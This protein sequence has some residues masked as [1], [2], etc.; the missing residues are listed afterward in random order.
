MKIKSLELTNWG[1][2]KK[3]SLQL[4]AGVVGIIGAN[5]KGKSNL[6][7][8][9]DY[10]LT[11]NL[12]KQKQ[13]LYIH[14]FGSPDG[15]TSASVKLIFEKGGKTGEITRTI[16]ASGS[17]RKLIWDESEWTKAAD[18]DQVMEAILG[19]DKAS[20][21]QA[22]FVKQGD[23]ARLVKGT[24]AER[25]TIFQ[26]LM[27]LG[28]LESCPDDIN[29]KIGAI[30]G[31]LQDMRPALELAEQ[32]MEDI[33]SKMQELEPATKQEQILAKVAQGINAVAVLMQDI[34][35]K[36]L[37]YREF[38]GH[39]AAAKESLQMQTA[40]L[41]V[42]GPDVETVR[43]AIEEYT[44]KIADSAANITAYNAWVSS[45]T[46]YKEA[47]AS[48]DVLQE[49][50]AAVG[51][52][53]ELRTELQTL[54]AEYK[55]STEQL[56]TL[57]SWKL[58][59][60]QLEAAK[61]AAAAEQKLFDEAKAK[62]DAETPSII[63]AL[64]EAEQQ[65][66]EAIIK[67]SQAEARFAGFL[68]SDAT[69]LCPICG[70][71]L[72]EETFMQPGE[73]RE[74]CCKRLSDA[75]ASIKL[76]FQERMQKIVLLDDKLRR[77][78]TGKH[79][80]VLKSKKDAVRALQQQL[81]SLDPDGKISYA[82]CEFN[83]TFVAALNT[84]MA[85]AETKI[86]AL[87][88]LQA[89]VNKAKARLVALESAM[90]VTSKYE[91]VELSELT[92]SHMQLLEHKNAM[93]S[94]VHKYETA[95]AAHTQA[96]DKETAL[97]HDVEQSNDALVQRWAELEQ[98]NDVVRLWLD[99]DPDEKL[100]RTSYTDVTTALAALNDMLADVTA[101]V[102]KYKELVARLNDISL[103]VT[104]LREAVDRNAEKLKL[105]DDLNIVKNMVS[106][107]G[108]PL[109]FMN[110][111]FH[112]LVGV[113]QDLLTRMGANFN[114]VPDPERA[115]SFLFSRTDDVS[116]FFMKQEQLSGGQAIRLS[117]A[118]LLACQQ[119]ILPEVG[120][121][122]LDEPSSH[123]DSEGVE[124]LRDL[125][126]SLQTLMTNTE[127]QL[128]VVDHNEKLNTAFETTVIL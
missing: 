104:T 61:E 114:V 117:L 58:T 94:A 13:E 103:R 98:D 102:V 38:S 44:S 26:K 99:I 128:L 36:N 100:S 34:S 74:M 71:H 63:E 35:R 122:V 88:S 68:A 82:D 123:I 60:T 93:E 2:H 85:T 77:L 96:K 16:T 14:N 3:K 66:K 40:S 69:A 119:L 5:G 92:A 19:A 55:K 121:L 75:C 22:V 10:A 25:Q 27:N 37:T 97:L 90:V 95:L 45:R 32:D 56:L 70:S 57:R 47:Q 20:L 62:S 84:Q 115:C 127:M 110:D 21:A 49:R 64:A 31:S 33:Q 113:V 17:R 111:V 12:N 72:A 43:A 65:Q 83:E 39:L 91:N 53:E 52:M 79:A 89:E 9:V 50:M 46:A 18:V 106:R 87:E 81:A 15:A 76:Q 42:Y 54:R 101:D 126:S 86:Q 41:K 125:F 78:D 51:D 11:G 118:V 48:L 116:G 67:Q 120:L 73:T 124:Q 108:V 28:F 105:I 107:T 29:A 6:L 80:S 4:D 112:K 59:Y 23:L 7:Q 1:P 30:R 8:A 109:A 24:P